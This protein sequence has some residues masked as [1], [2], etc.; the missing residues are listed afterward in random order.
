MRDNK[1]LQL[2]LI[3]IVKAILEQMPNAY[4]FVLRKASL[5]AHS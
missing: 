1:A 2:K 5:T 4:I 3:L